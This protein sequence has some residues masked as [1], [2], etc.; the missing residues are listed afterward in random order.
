MALSKKK[1]AELKEEKG[2]QQI[3]TAVVKSEKFIE[4][5]QKQLLIG[6][7]VVIL[8]VC[9]VFA[10]KQFYLE[11]RNKDAQVAMFKAEQYYSAGQDSLALFGDDNGNL[12]FEAV[13]QTYGSTKA[14][15]LAKA[16][17][18]ICNAR[19]GNY[20]QAIQYL[21]G[22]SADDKLFAYQAKVTL[23]DCYVNTGNLDEAVKL[24]EKAAKGVDNDLY[25]PVYYKKAAMIYREQKNYDKVIETFS[26]IKNSYMSS[27]EAADADRYIEEAKLLK[28]SN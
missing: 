28:G 24:F 25:A 13:A 1:Q 14:G 10:Y 17:A 6:I 3:D 8:V 2:W 20:E 5:Y 22:F 4:K 11:P 19:L 21:K 9:A 16:Y 18:G 12:G 27:M 23:G 15:K 26:L 7:G